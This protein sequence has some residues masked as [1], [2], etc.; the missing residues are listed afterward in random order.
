VRAVHDFAGSQDV[1]VTLWDR[2]RDALGSNLGWDIGHSDWSLFTIF[3]G[4]S[5]QFSGSYLY[6]TTTASF[7]MSLRKAD[8]WMFMWR[9]NGGS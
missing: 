8:R 9:V 7:Q 6:K 3:L 4:P 1:A 5:R 2:V